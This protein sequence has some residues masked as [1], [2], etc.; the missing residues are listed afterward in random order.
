M[1][2]MCDSKEFHAAG[3]AN[4]MHRSPNFS[5]EDDGY[6]SDEGIGGY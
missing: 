3:P 4:E 5:R 6:I 2:C 1:S